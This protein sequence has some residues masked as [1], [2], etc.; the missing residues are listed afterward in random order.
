MIR[1]KFRG[2]Q[3]QPKL[4]SATEKALS[5]NQD[6]ANAWVTRS[7]RPLFAKPNQGGDTALALT[8]LNNALAVDPDHLQALMFR[9]VAH[10]KLENPEASDSDWQRA[11]ALNANIAGSRAR[12]ME[13][14]APAE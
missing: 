4:E 1:S 6:N 9:S 5:L 14:A 11:L 10:A 13:M 3:L 2:M 12:L 8:C 7:R